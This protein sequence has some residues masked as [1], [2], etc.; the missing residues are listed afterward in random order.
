MFH[1]PSEKILE[2]ENPPPLSHHFSNGPSLTIK[3]YVVITYLIC[4]IQNRE[5]R[6]Y[7]IKRRASNKRRVSKVKS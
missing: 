4:I 1:F 6:I 7:S 5:Y 3:T 2:T